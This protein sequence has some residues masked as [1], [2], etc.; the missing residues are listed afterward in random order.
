MVRHFVKSILSIIALSIILVW[1]QEERSS[2][3][4]VHQGNL[5]FSRGDCE[6]AQYIFQEALKLEPT[7]IS[8][9]LGKGRAL[10]CQRATQL[11]IEEFQKVIA[12]DPSNI[13][14]YIQL[15]IAYLN[16]YLDDPTS[17]PDGLDKAFNAVGQAESIDATNPRVLNM[18]G[19]ILYH[20]SDFEG[21]RLVLENAVSLA[22][23]EELLPSE[24]AQIHINLGRVYRSL[25]QGQ[26][27]LTS[28]RRGV[29]LNPRNSEAHKLVGEM[30][31]FF[32]DDCDQALYELTQ[33]ANLNKESLPALSSLAI[34]TFECGNEA[35]AEPWIKDAL[36]LDE[37]I[38]LPMLYIYLARVY[39][40]QSRLDDAVREA[41][42]GA[43]LLTNDAEGFYWLGHIYQTKGE[44]NAAKEAYLQALELEPNN[45]LANEALKSLQ[46]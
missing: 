33:G 40:S 25:D 45:I 9:M 16:Q 26:L 28:F 31:Y 22:D 20:K 34:V 44:L 36:E 32:Q 10:V 3:D 17:H 7:S 12:A 43:L 21:A 6:L 30:L 23:S 11:G 18:K 38:S 8:A 13:G 29:M 2:E 27:A 41:Q 35:G 5:Y 37:N 46:N 15:S 4:L 39:L 24:A 1:A 42:K 19:V 14:A